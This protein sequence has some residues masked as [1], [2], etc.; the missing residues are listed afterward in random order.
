MKEH[1]HTKL[2]TYLIGSLVALVLTFLVALSHGA[3]SADSISLAFAQL[4]NACL[5]T[6]VMYL[7]FGALMW[8]ATTGL[9]DIFGYGF[10]SLKYLFTP[11]KKDPEE[12]GYYEY[13]LQKQEKRETKAV[14]YFMLVI[15]AVVLVLSFVFLALWNVTGAVDV[16]MK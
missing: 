1:S 9:F 8:I 15:G 6:A 16:I 4:S 14:P 13:V 2:K 11:L 10:K 5:V 7:G 12:G 3:F